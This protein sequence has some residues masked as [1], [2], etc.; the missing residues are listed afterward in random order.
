MKISENWLREWI[1]PPLACE[2]LCDQLTNMGLEVD[3]CEKLA[4][5]HLDVIVG[6]VVSISPHPAGD[7]LQICQV[8]DGQ[9]VH[10]VVCGATNVYAG[11]RAPFAKLGS[12]LSKDRIIKKA[13][14]RGVESSGMLCSAAELDLGD[15][16]RE[17]L[18]LGANCVAGADLHSALE[19]DDNIIELDLTPNRGDCFSVRGVARELSV[20]NDMPL[21]DSTIEPVQA[22]INARIP[23]ALHHPKAC[24][25]YLG[26]VIRG[27]DNSRQSPLW[28][29]EKLRRSGIRS[30]NPLVDIANFVMME[31]GQPLHAFDLKK[32]NAGIHVRC[33]MPGERLGLLDGSEMALQKTDLAICDIDGPVA[34]AGIM[35][36]YDSAV[37][38]ATTD[39]F[40]ECA[41]FDPLTIAATA[42]RI[43]IQTDASTRYERGVDFELQA[44]AMERATALILELI[45]GEAGPVVEAVESEHLHNRPTV[46]L[47]RERLDALVGE[48]IETGTVTK[49]F[50]R[51]GFA[52][53]F[54]GSAWRVKAPSYRFDIAIEEDLIE[55]VCR[56][57]G[58]N[59]ISSS[60]P[61]TVPALRR[62]SKGSRSKD[63]LRDLIAAMGYQEAITYSF[64]QST[65]NQLLDYGAQTPQ[66][67]NPLASERSVMRSTLLPGLLETLRMN[68]SRQATNAR[69]FEIGQCF[70]YI[71]V[72]LEQTE[73][74]G[75][76]L[77][78]ERHPALWGYSGASADFFD[79]KGDV[80]T[81][82]ETTGSPFEF[83]ELD[84][85]C[86][87]PRQCASVSLEGQE[88]G[89]MGRIH[90][91]IAGKLDIPKDV[92]LFEARLD[93]LL[94]IDSRQAREI[95][96]YPMVRRDI[97][98]VVA[99][100]VSAKA[101]ESAVRHELGDIL[102]DFTI[103][104]L[105]TGDAI[106]NG[107]KSIALR[108]TM[109]ESHDTLTD[110]KI[111]DLVERAR[112]ALKSKTG[113]D[114]R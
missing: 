101:L 100:H 112:R 63:S 106:K 33:A 82:L 46:T 21:T 72:E 65:E 110:S 45:D 76:V 13:N 10:C 67:S 113:A 15:N 54:S 109:Q 77:W 104:D 79:L 20:L 91:G 62:I 6:E 50:D 105:Y 37:S 40:L 34:L 22:T 3:S 59:V 86:L 29:T 26:R 4:S 103:F 51:L 114:F 42:R 48:G 66:L 98:C 92:F 24:P 99:D 74:L 30:I 49:A 56:I 41:F 107:Y 75:L 89:R 68:I 83:R 78:G 47:R 71:G 36:G 58:Y 55:E 25:R 43:G 97:A 52:P 102:R 9:S 18:D 88:V 35:G 57:V 38:E 84:D 44:R 73:K 2:Q 31:L 69:F 61:S 70:R 14:I 7:R 28:L 64:V 23:I 81:V 96:R 16:A 1:D 27:I 19:L 17:I 94:K 85:K 87:H 108:L 12:R 95:S 53:E 11:M 93:K 5:D 80:E 60:M 39:L 32:L 8:S 111:I 90:P